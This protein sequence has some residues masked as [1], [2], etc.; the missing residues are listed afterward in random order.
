[1]QSQDDI[2]QF[3]RG[4]TALVTPSACPE[5]KLYRAASLSTLAQAA[6]SVFAG[7]PIAPPYWAIPWAGGQALARH[8][9][10]N[11]WLVRGRRVLDFQA[12]CGVAGIA[13]ALVGAGVVEACD[14]DVLARVA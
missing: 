13:A 5:L 10:E 6:E 4:H 3:I 12:G 1:M 8:V 7:T 11:R 14:D 9:I 2:A